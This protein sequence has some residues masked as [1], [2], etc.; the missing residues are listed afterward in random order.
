MPT[1]NQRPTLSRAHA[2]AQA[3]PPRDHHDARREAR[4]RDRRDAV[5]ALT[6]MGYPSAYGDGAARRLGMKVL[7]PPP[8]PIACAPSTASARAAAK[9]RRLGL[10]GGPGFR[11]GSDE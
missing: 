9:D 10:I 4:I 11:L 2:D 8:G 7:R 5:A 6:A 3:K 1:R